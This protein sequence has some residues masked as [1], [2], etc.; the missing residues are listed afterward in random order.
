MPD[1]VIAARD[2]S[3][4]EKAGADLVCD[5]R[6][7]VAVLAKA[8]AVPYR[9]V[10]LTAGR[11]DMNAG[12]GRLVLLG[13]TERVEYVDA[14]SHVEDLKRY[15]ARGYVMAGNRCAIVTDRD[16][17]VIEVHPPSRGKVDFGGLTIERCPPRPQT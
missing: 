14:P 7:D 15:R 8:L 17:D 9:E 2:S 3:T 5:G 16:T 10:V 12:T 4:A 13:C 6:T 11:F 1:L